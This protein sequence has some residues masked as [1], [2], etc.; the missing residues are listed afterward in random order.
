LKD[1]RFSGRA[2]PCPR[3]QLLAVRTRQ[4]FAVGADDLIE[5]RQVPVLF[6]IDMDRVDLPVLVSSEVLQ[7]DDVLVRVG[8][9][10]AANAAQLV[11][12]DRDRLGRV[13]GRRCPNVH[14]A[15]ARRQEADPPPVGTDL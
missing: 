10:I 3:P 7:I 12:G 6:R 15:V 1:R 9:E 13:V 8:P 4:G 11:G 14:H 2:N 5:R